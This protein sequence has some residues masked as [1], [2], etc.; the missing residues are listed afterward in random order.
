MAVLVS[1]GGVLIHFDIEVSV[2]GVCSCFGKVRWGVYH[3]DM[4][5]RVGGVCGCFGKGRWGV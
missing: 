4:E 1:V 2:G 3:F 5:L